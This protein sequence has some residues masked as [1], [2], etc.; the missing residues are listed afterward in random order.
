M[1]LIWVDYVEDDGEDEE[2]VA[3]TDHHQDRQVQE[4]LGKN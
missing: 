1:H 4:G 3:H 2:E